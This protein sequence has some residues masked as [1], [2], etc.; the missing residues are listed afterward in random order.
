MHEKG[1]PAS[2]NA[3]QCGARKGSKMKLS[4]IAAVCIAAMAGN[5]SAEGVGKLVL[6]ISSV[7]TVDTRTE[8]S[9]PGFVP[10]PAELSN[11]VPPYSD[12]QIAQATPERAKEMAAKNAEAAD[13]HHRA[14]MAVAWDNWQRTQDYMQGVKAKLLGTAFGRQINQAL[15]KFAGYASQTLNPECLEFFHRLDNT[16]GNA[17]SK[18]T[19]KGGMDVYAGAYFIKIVF[20]DPAERTAA[21]TVGGGQ[22]SRTFLTQRASVQLQDCGG[23]V[24]YADNIKAEKAIVGA[25]PEE[26]REAAVELI[27]ECL[28]QMAAKINEHF[29]ATVMF[30]VVP[31]A[32]D[33]EFNPDAC[34]LEVDGVARQ[35]G[36]EIGLL[37]S[38]SHSVE[39]SCDGYRQKLSP[40]MKF[41]KSGEV[42]IAMVSTACK[43]TVTVV[44][45]EDALIE[46]LEG[47]ET[48]E[49]L[50]SGEAAVVKQGKYSLKVSA[51]GYED[52]VQP[53]P[54]NG[55]KKD[56]KVVLVK[57]VE[58]AK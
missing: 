38:V 28:R 51:E 56:V 19:G 45:P 10:V 39:A 47:A 24:E 5:L 36:E 18:F 54:L 2:L 42:K 31:P 57:K 12:A 20:D 23:K 6:R 7:E 26:K 11:M 44:G 46:V 14:M 52:K 34:T 4:V 37:K 43:L 53:L 17:E 25:S 8:K 3:K 22:V 41:S 13:E 48:V 27:E 16:E 35:F 33:E 30:K 21:A 1:R 55:A 49:T 50:T 40:K 29:V 15:D 32:K 9:G 58:V